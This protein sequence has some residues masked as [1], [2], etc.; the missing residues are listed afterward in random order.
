MLVL[1][2][3]LVGCTV[4]R[5]KEPFSEGALLSDDQAYVDHRYA[6]DA[7]SVELRADL[8]TAGYVCD[9]VPSGGHICARST[10]VAAMPGC[11]D[12]FTVRINPPHVAAAQNR[13]CTGVVAPP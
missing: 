13:R 12:V 5:P 4:L 1:A 10:P 7:L 6:K 11:A 8:A 9:P 3:L 2:A